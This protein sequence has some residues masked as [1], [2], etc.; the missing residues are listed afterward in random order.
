[1]YDLKRLALL[2]DG[3]FVT[4]RLREEVSRSHPTADHIEKLAKLVLSDTALA[5]MT[6]FRI[7]YYDSPP[8]E[9][10]GV[11]PLTKAKIEFGKKEVAARN[12]AI[13][14]SLAGRTD[15]A[16]RRGR[17]SLDGWKLRGSVLNRPAARTEL[18]VKEEDVI[19]DFKQKEVDLKIG[20]DIAWISLKQIASNICLVTADSDFVPAM[21]FARREGVRIYLQT[22][23]QSPVKEL[24]EHADVVLSYPGFRAAGVKPP[25]EP[26]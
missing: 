6:L 9:R 18:T 16:V 15:F 1:M 24:K 7:F 25:V 2:M 11:H 12:A 17:L 10:T 8:Y 5:G 23:G 4:K 22:M 13:L 19:P 26:L 20:L 3:G 21:K 14:D